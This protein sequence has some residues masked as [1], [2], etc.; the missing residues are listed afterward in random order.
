MLE[1]IYQAII[2]VTPEVTPVVTPVVTPEVERLINALQE[3][4]LGKQEILLVLGL[5]DEKNLREL[6][7]KP[8]LQSGLVE[9][10]I[11]DKPTSSKQQYRIPEKRKLI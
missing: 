10:T 3:K 6:Y 8:A 1:A 11:P 9:L 7:I 5:K 4:P 2:T